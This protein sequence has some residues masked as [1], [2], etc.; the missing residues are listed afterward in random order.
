MTAGSWQPSTQVLRVLRSMTTPRSS[1]AAKSGTMPQ[2]WA[3]G[4]AWDEDGPSQ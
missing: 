1:P 2:R 3:A 4:G